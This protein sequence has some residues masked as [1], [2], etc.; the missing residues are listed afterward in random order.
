MTTYELTP[1]LSVRPLNDVGE[2]LNSQ[3]QDR[4]SAPGFQMRVEVDA[5]ALAI[6]SIPE[7][8]V[9]CQLSSNDQRELVDQQTGTVIN[10]GQSALITFSAI[11][12]QDGQCDLEFVATDVSGLPMSQQLSL[13]VDRTPPEIELVLPVPGATLD[14]LDDNDNA[15]PGIQFPTRLRV[16]GAAGQTMT[17]GTVPAQSGEAL[18]SILGEEDCETVD[19]GLLTYTNGNQLLTATVNDNCGNTQEFSQNIEGD[20]NV[21]IV[22]IE[23]R[24]QAFIN[25]SEDLDLD[26]EGCQVEVDVR[27]AG[28]TNIENVEF[29]IC[30]TNQA[31]ALSPLCG[32]QSDASQGQ[33]STSAQGNNIRCPITLSDG[34]HE[35]SLVA[36]EN[37]VD[38]R[39][40]TISVLSDCTAP[41]VVEITIAEDLNTDQCINAQERTNA[42]SSGSS[43]SFTVDFQVNG[44]EDTRLVR[45]FSL[46]GQVPLGSAELS[47]GRGTISNVNLPQGEHFL[48][49]TGTDLVGNS[50]P[51]QDN[52]DFAPLLLMIDTEAPVPELLRP[53]ANQ[54]INIADDLE[55]Q[56]GAQ[57]QPQVNSGWIS[58]EP[59]SLSLGLDGI[60]VQRE[61]VSNPSYTFS[62][63]LLSEGNHLISLVAEDSCGNAGS[64]AG[65][66]TIGDRPDWSAPL[67]VPISVDLSSPVLTLNGIDDGQELSAADDANQSP[68]DGF[69]V[70][71]TIDTT[72][73]EAGQELKIYSGEERLP[74]LPAQ[75][76]TTIADSQ[77][78]S[79][80][81]T[82]PPGPHTLSVRSN[83]ACDNPST[84][85]AKTI[86]IAVDGCSSQ[87]TS[88]ASG[89]LLGPNQGIIT[90]DNKL[91]LDVSGRVDLL[92]PQCAT[93][94]AELL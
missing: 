19:L 58:G 60:V 28:F 4:S 39:S 2:C 32:N 71:V 65:F 70:N 75:L 26:T 67:S 88:L 13:N 74:T 49:L 62:T 47:E 12:L 59:V 61:S 68:A 56:A 45:L 69:Q 14:L 85:E 94:Q 76:L 82:L 41:N 5:D 66:N 93:A 29:A 63:I 35:I 83:D 89:Q 37:G 23:P 46:P 34:E 55:E 81:L 43:A 11:T 79:A 52:D 90:Q 30:A 87:I 54:C 77:S 3:V 48:Y 22:I 84:S 40:N 8:Q 6:N 92:D 31:G 72:G 24:D 7:V 42:S 57:Y 53:I 9:Y 80:T 73:L 10:L 17:V 38:L 20:T 18:T 36:R 86:T 16:C 50:L 44:I 21:S 15:T 1:R 91:R 78:L 27:S 51:N 64:I 25:R 33:C